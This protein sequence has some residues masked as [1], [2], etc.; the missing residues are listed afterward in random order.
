[1]WG[2]SRWVGEGVDRQ[3]SRELGECMSRWVEIWVGG[4][5]RLGIAGGTGG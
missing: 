3:I 2:D 5:T 4:H 1:M